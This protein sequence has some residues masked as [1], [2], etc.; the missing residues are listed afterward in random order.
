MF[1]VEERLENN[2]EEMITEEKTWKLVDQDPGRN[3]Y[4]LSSERAE[5]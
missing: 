5:R 4:R 2:L 1:F 3:S